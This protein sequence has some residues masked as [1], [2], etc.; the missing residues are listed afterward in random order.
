MRFLFCIALFFGPAL[1]TEAQHSPHQPARLLSTNARVA[2]VTI[3]PGTAIYN[4]W[5]HTA[6]RITDPGGLDVLFNYGT[7]EFT[8][9]FVFSFAHGALDYTLST[10]PPADS[11]DFYAREGRGVIEQTLNLSPVETA[12]LWAL[13]VDNAREENRTY[14]YHFLYDNCSTRPRDIVED[15]VGKQF[16][17][18]EPPTGTTF[19]ELLRPYDA[20]APLLRFGL[21]LLLGLNLDEEVTTRSAAFLPITLMDQLNEATR[22]DGQRIVSRT[23]TV[24]R[25]PSTAGAAFDWPSALGW[26]LVVIGLIALVRGWAKPYRRS[27]WDVL[28][29]VVAGIAGFM[30][31]GMWTL[32]LHDVTERNLNLLWLWPTHAP[33]AWWVLRRTQ[34]AWVRIYWIATA[35][36]AGLTALL[37]FVLPQTLPI[38][39][40]PLALLIAV[41]ALGQSRKPTHRTDEPMT[42]GVPS[43]PE[44]RQVR[45]DLGR[46]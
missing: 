34:P 20:P 15:A 40:L 1:A 12:R 17:Y 21:N 10:A 24:V 45:A 13:L 18:P 35:I 4:R 9:T 29:F 39:G 22:V 25:T 33:A 31:L 11:Y 19:R 30:L 41:R 36:V 28:L 46:A 8:D 38:A 32:T 2:L 16:V 5:G 43:R 26:V 23:D 7:F 6:L 3:T 27:R 44:T 42:T 37:W 14:R